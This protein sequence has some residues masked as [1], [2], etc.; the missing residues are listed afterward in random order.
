M[1]ILLLFWATTSYA[2]APGNY[3]LR[4]LI[5]V[6]LLTQATH[7]DGTHL[8]AVRGLIELRGFDRVRQR[9]ELN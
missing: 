9:G 5:Q 2:R 6:L 7:L 4:N 1:K 3:N 8:D